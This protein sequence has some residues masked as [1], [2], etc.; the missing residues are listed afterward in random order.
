MQFLELACCFIGFNAVPFLFVQ[1][2]QKPCMFNL[3]HSTFIS[4]TLEPKILRLVSLPLEVMVV[5]VVV[6]E[7]VVV[8]EIVVVVVVAAVVVPVVVVIVI[9]VVVAEVIAERTIK[10]K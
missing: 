9:V 8:I 5:A 7:V 10:V 4:D 2:L 6:V 1:N 3:V